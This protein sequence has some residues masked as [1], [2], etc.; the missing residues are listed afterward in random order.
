MSVQVPPPGM[1]H[2][3]RMDVLRRM[4]KWPGF[5]RQTL[6][7][8]RAHDKRQRM[9]R[10]ARA[11]PLRVYIAHALDDGTFIDAYHRKWTTLP[12]AVN[13]MAAGEKP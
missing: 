13:H 3:W 2:Y 9:L 1:P 11:R 4:A 6:P 12:G 5:A 8:S 10:W 7:Q